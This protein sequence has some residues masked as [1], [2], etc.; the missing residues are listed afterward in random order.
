MKIS[1]LGPHGTFTE[2]S[3]FVYTKK[4][5]SYNYLPC[6]TIHNA[7]LAVERGEADEAIVPFENSIEGT[8]TATLDTLIFDVNLYIKGEIVI[9]VLQ[10]MMVKKSYQ[11]E[12]ITKILSHPQGL[13]QCSDFLRSKFPA[14]PT[15]TVSSTAESA[16]IVSENSEN[17]AAIAAKSAAKEYGLKILYPSIQNNCHNETR[18]LILSKENTAICHKNWKTSIV[19]STENRPGELYRILDIISIWN[20]NMTK[21]ESRPMKNRLGTYNFF[22]DLEAENETDLEDALRMIQR[23]ASYFKPLGSYPVF[24]AIDKS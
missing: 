1:Y 17:W 20:L 18:F 12:P 9:P 2:Y 16:K 7:L 11:G 21:I 24:Q 23:K 15:E 14:C 8:V 22:V 3:A 19:F 4:S 6:S 10:N 5:P 13:A